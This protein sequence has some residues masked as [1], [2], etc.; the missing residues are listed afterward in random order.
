[1]YKSRRVL[2]TRIIVLAGLPICHCHGGCTNFYYQNVVPKPY[3]KWYHKSYFIIVWVLM[4]IIYSIF[5]GIIASKIAGMIVG[6]GLQCRRDTG[7]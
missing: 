7:R 6:I 4:E 1:M 3:R 5:I 2:H